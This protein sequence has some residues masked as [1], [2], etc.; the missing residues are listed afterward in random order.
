M[1]RAS[2]KTGPGAC[3]PKP[4]IEAE[5]KMTTVV[6]N[7]RAVEFFERLLRVGDEVEKR[8]AKEARDDGPRP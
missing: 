7:D 5:N 8:K 4:P 6:N 3:T 2:K 1:R